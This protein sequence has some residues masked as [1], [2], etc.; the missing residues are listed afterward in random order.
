MP[1]ISRTTSWGFV[2]RLLIALAILA[3]GAYWIYSNKKPE[4][5]NLVAS[6]RKLEISTLVASLQLEADGSGGA[7]LEELNAQ[8]TPGATYAS[9]QE[10]AEAINAE[11]A[12]CKYFSESDEYDPQMYDEGGCLFTERGEGIK[13][14]VELVEMQ[15]PTGSVL[16]RAARRGAWKGMKEFAAM[17]MQEESLLLAGQ[18]WYV[19]G[20]EVFL[21]QVQSLLGGDILDLFND[22]QEEIFVNR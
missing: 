18:N 7:D 8:S 4:L 17:L 11:G 22:A 3:V 10:L 14:T 16:G 15:T 2:V 1:V 9:A 5:S 19:G 12:T 13:I 20:E 6:I 21:L